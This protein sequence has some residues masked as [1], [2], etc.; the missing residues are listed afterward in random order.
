[1]RTVGSAAS[2]DQYRAQYAV[3]APAG[4]PVAQFGLYSS[5]ESLS[6]PTRWVA[7]WPIR[8]ALEAANVLEMSVLLVGNTL[9]WLP[10]GAGAAPRPF[11]NMTAGPS[12]RGDDG[13][14]PPLASSGLPGATVPS[15]G[16]VAHVTPVSVQLSSA[17]KMAW[18]L[19]SP[20]WA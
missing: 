6:S 17:R 20:S 4:Q 18:W 10:A 7:T 3:F 11:G 2:R 16:R 1:G 13:M 9:V 15:E 5:I 19:P 14:S 12:A 8:S